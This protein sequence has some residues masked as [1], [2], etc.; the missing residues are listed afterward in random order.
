MISDKMYNIGTKK[1]VIRE[2]FDFGKE[3]KRKYGEDKV[4]DFSLGNPSAPVPYQLTETMIKLLKEKGG[5]IHEYPP[6][7]GSINLR[8]ALA[9]YINVKYNENVTKENFFI[10]CG[11]APSLVLSL[12]SIVSSSKDEVIVLAPF[13]P[14]YRTYIT[15]SGAN[16]VINPPKENMEIDFAS[17]KENINE[18]TKAIIVNS[19]NNPTGLI[20]SKDSINKLTVLLKEKENEYGNAI[21]LLSDEPYREL[22]YVHDKLPYIPDYYDDTIICYSYSKALSVPGERIGYIMVGKK[23]KEYEK[24]MKALSG[25]A[26]TMGYVCAPSLMQEALALNLN[27]SVDIS[28]YIENRDILY[29]KLTELGYESIR[30]DGAFYLFVKAK[31]NSAREFSENAKKFN[32]ILVPSEPFGCEGFV[33]ISYC[34]PKRVIISSLDSFERLYNFYEKEV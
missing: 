7:Q 15:G 29:N 2:L 14:E 13:F 20:Y 8:S 10:T 33:R 34:V 25:A 3:L 31:G 5:S 19:P 9:D 6:I 22:T 17:L 16:I 4:Y 1:A 21:Y 18:N 32:L 30:P 24:I 28:V 27:V 11:A 23:V 12:H 26:R